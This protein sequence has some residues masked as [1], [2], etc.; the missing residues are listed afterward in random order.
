MELR[1][2]CNARPADLHAISDVVGFRLTGSLNAGVTATDMT[3]RIVE[4]LREH[5]VVGKFV[6]FFGQGM[7]ALSLPDRATMQTWLLN[8]AQHV[9]SSQLTITLYLHETLR[10]TEEDIA[11]VETTVRL[12]ACGMIQVLQ[13]RVTPHFSNWICL[14]LNLR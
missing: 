12:K 8:M 10:R 11:G 4:M 3:L 14:L 1:Q 6:E 7:A 2:S 9:V 13:K 5:G